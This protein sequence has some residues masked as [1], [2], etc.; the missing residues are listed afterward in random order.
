MEPVENDLVNQ[1]DRTMIGQTESVREM[2]VNPSKAVVQ[3]LNY[4]T[5]TGR[6]VRKP[7]YYQ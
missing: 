4:R 6:V 5:R 3:P 2:Y 1:L 7:D